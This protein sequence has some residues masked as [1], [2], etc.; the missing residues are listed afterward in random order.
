MFYKCVLFFL[1]VIKHANN[2]PRE[3]PVISFLFVCLFNDQL[4]VRCTPL[5]Y[6]GYFYPK[7]KVKMGL[8]ILYSLP[9]WTTNWENK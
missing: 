4:V 7:N 3:I 2:F 9:F 5:K 1:N 8:I 6:I